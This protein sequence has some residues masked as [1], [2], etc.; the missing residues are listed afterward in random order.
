MNLQLKSIVPFI[1]LPF[2]LIGC[3][4]EHSPSHEGKTLFKG[5]IVK[6]EYMLTRGHTILID[7]NGQE[8]TLQGFPGIP[9]GEVEI[10][11]KGHRE[12]KVF[13]AP[14]PL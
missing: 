7:E 12:Y 4:G 10:Y 11:E 13:Q 5:R 2:L 3:G 8:I 6:V 1:A 9:T 14:I